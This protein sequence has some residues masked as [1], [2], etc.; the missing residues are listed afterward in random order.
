MAHVVKKCNCRDGGRKLG[1]ECPL[2]GRRDHGAWWF[3][4][5]APSGPD[6]KRRRPW[7]GPFPTKSK[8][9]EE[10]TRLEARVSDGEPT[11][12]RTTRVSAYL[13]D[14]LERKRKTLKPSTYDSYEEAVTLYYRPGIGHLRLYQV[15][16]GHLEAL[17]EA[18][19]AIHDPPEKPSELLRRLIAARATATWTRDGEEAP[20]LWGR[21]PIGP[22][23]IH[24]IHAVIRS[25]LGSAVKRGILARNAAMTVDLPKVP[26]R[27]PLVWT[28]AR[29]AKWRLTGRRPSPVMVWLP[30]HTGRFLDCAEEDG[31]RLYPLYHLA[32]T[33]GLRRGE[34]WALEW[35]NVELDVAAGSG[36]VAVREE[37][38]EV[39]QEAGERTSVKSDSGWR[40]IPLDRA[41]TLLLELW[42]RRQAAE[43]E[44]AGDDWRESGRVFTADDGAPLRIDFI[45]DHFDVLVARHGLPPV[46]FHDLRHC[47][48]TYLLASG[49]DIKMV[50][51][52]LGHSKSAFT[53]DTYVNVLPDLAVAAAEA[54]VA[55]IPR[56]RREA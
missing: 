8:A 6:G 51:E 26:K 41:N 37:E 29:V 45:G 43:R 21:R 2:L 32:V 10:A 9:Q 46:R 50:A 56:K 14:W 38:A 1:N 17:Y 23:R 30:E 44:S 18:M 54:A 55:V 35:V 4:Y 36:W 13:E 48:A 11:A 52:T 49:S 24:R 22:A 20:G 5:E 16:E 25:A 53:A 15:D 39:G 28:P 19:Q 31:E 42:R 34:L 40:T 12:D 33:R 7:A 3:R 47:A 27:K